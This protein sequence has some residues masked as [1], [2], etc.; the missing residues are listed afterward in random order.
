M[1]GVDGPPVYFQGVINAQQNEVCIAFIACFACI[2][3][4]NQ[5][6]QTAQTD[7][8]A[9]FAETAENAEAAETSQTAQTAKGTCV[10]QSTASTPALF[11]LISYS[12]SR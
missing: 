11:L 5:T 3:C 9:E 1:R 4:I 6:S 12:Y 7:E 10:A 2:A 8:T